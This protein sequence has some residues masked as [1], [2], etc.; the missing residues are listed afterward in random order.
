MKRKYHNIYVSNIHALETR[1]WR[2][3]VSKQDL[4]GAWFESKRTLGV[5]MMT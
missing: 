3:Q 5:Y 2:T 4:A 1:G